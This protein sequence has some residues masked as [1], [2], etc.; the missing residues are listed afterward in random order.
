M[1][2]FFIKLGLM[3]SSF[4]CKSQC[5]WNSILKK[6]MFNVELCPNKKCICKL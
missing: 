5:K 1:G 2:K 6:L 4:W 3:I